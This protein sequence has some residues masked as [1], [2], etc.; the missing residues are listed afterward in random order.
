M[1]SE[2]FSILLHC[3]FKSTHYSKNITQTLDHHPVAVPIVEAQ[4]DD[5]QHPVSNL[6][7]TP[8]HQLLYAVIKSGN[9]VVAKQCI[10]SCT[11]YELQIV[12]IIKNQNGGENVIS[13][14]STM[15]LLLVPD[16]L[17]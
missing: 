2:F 5:Y 15:A 6:T 9:H 12:V 3:I 10:T 17:F 16:G 8:V 14:T 1:R 7:G 4:Y 11:G 13:V